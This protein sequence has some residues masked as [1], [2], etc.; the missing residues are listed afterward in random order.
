VCGGVS[1][2]AG[3]YKSVKELLNISNAASQFINAT[4]K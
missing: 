1:A 2:A 4:A 3:P